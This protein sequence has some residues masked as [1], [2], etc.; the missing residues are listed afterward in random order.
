MSNTNLWSALHQPSVY[1]ILASQTRDCVL[2]AT[3][4]CTPGRFITPASMLSH[5]LL[6]TSRT[7]TVNWYVKEPVSTSP[8]P[9]TTNQVYHLVL[10]RDGQPRSA[11]NAPKLACLQCIQRLLVSPMNWV[12]G[13][14]H[15][16]STGRPN[17]QEMLEDKPS[18]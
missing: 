8:E 1:T 7:T 5:K 3:V 6:V 15:V 13:T 18:K 2:S 17:F 16:S 10:P 14:T 4:A 11:A 12:H 9:K